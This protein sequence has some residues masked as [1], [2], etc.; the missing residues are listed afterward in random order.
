[1]EIEEKEI[2]TEKREELN[3]GKPGGNDRPSNREKITE[4]IFFSSIFVHFL[5]TLYKIISKFS[6]NFTKLSWVERA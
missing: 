4:M 1:M 2:K 5:W 6:I 3:L